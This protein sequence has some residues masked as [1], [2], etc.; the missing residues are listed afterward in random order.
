MCSNLRFVAH[1][2]EMLQQAFQIFSE[3]VFLLLFLTSARLVVLVKVSVS[4][5]NVSQ[6]LDPIE[7]LPLCCLRSRFYFDLFHS[8]QDER[9]S[10]SVH[11]LV[12]VVPV[13]VGVRL[14]GSAA[15]F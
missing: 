13:T 15:M 11:L 7:C 12:F 9:A 2:G 5:E 4:A 6:T 3:T 10:C 14:A 1:A 8:E